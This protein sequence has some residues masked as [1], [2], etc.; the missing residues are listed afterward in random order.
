MNDSSLVTFYPKK[1]KILLNLFI[2]AIFVAAGIT[3]INENAL[4]AWATIIFFGIAIIIFIIVL[5]PNSSY[6]RL[7]AQGFEIRTLY[8]TSFME[9][10]DVEDFGVGH[11]RL[12]KM[13]I[14]KLNSNNM[15]SKTAK[16]AKMLTGMEGALP[17]TYGMSADELSRILSEWKMKYKKII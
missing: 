17:D 9:W 14:L 15:L 3:M 11:I 4:L 2:S 13:V 6:L 12:K 8:R 16:V 10:N 7:S 1:T 5:L